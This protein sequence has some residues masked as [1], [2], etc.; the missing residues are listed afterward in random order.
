MRHTSSGIP[1]RGQPHLETV[2]P[3]NP[4]FTD[5][6]ALISIL[7]PHPQWPI[8]GS[9]GGTS[10]G[11]ASTADQSGGGAPSLQADGKLQAGCCLSLSLIIGG[12][13]RATDGHQFQF[14]SEMVR[15]LLY[16]RE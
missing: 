9:V 2:I 10:C 3:P 15:H 16:E 4:D 6:G 7:P 5:G 11:R 8:E 12:D 13:A 1:S 14:G